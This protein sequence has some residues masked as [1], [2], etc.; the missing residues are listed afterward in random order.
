MLVPKNRF[1]RSTYADMAS[2]ND[3]ANNISVGEGAGS[4]RDSLKWV[5]QRLALLNPHETWHPDFVS[6][7]AR[8]R[9]QM[10]A[11]RHGW[12]RMAGWSAVL[13][14]ASMILALG[15]TS[16]PAPRVLA[17][18]CIDCSI[19]IWQTISPSSGAVAQLEP[20]RQRHIVKDLEL[21]DANGFIVKLSDL[22]GKV[23]VLNFWATWCGGCQIEIPWFVEFFK[24]YNTAGLEVVGVSL[25]VDGWKSVLPYL[26][27]KT[28]PYTIVI[29]SDA[30]AKEFNVTA[31][32]VTLLIDREGRVA[33]TNTGVPAKST[34]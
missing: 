10:T 18:R 1:E 23:V 17:Q 27:K 34:Y 29:G 12:P 19:A 31:M 3:I 14:A 22:K 6:A 5:D 20:V 7:Q 16:A 32:P 28:I 25:D 30:I 4:T 8:L 21:K 13:V 9:Q 33:A 15:L 24:K 2:N 26:K 11:P